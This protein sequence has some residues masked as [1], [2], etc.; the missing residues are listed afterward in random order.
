MS[1]HTVKIAR[2]TGFT[3]ETAKQFLQ[4]MRAVPLNSL[5][6]ESVGPWIYEGS[7]DLQPKALH[8]MAGGE[9]WLLSVVKPKS[10]EI[11]FLIGTDS[12]CR[13]FDPLT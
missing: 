5:S 11:L 6:E 12:K 10:V 1:K 3:V 2:L 8:H 9:G 4:D 7:Y 13:T